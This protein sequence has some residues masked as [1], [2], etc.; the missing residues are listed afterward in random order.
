ML[1]STAINQTQ[2]D[3]RNKRKPYGVHRVLHCRDELE[4]NSVVYHFLK[5]NQSS[6][7]SLLVC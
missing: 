3:H 2:R 1:S 7:L 6:T 5:E 4:C